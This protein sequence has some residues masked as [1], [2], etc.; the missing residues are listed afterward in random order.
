[1][2][3]SWFQIWKL[4]LLRPSV[5]S[6]REI[7]RQPNASV[8]SAFTSVFLCVSASLLVSLLLG[9]LLS[10]LGVAGFEGIW[11]P[12][13]SSLFLLA[14]YVVMPLTAGFL[15]VGALIAIAA[16]TQKVASVLGGVGNVSMVIPAVAALFAPLA[17]IHFLTL[18]LGPFIGSFGSFLLLYAAILTVIAFE[19]VN[20]IGWLK[21]VAST[22]VVILVVL[23][24]VRLTEAAL[25][26]L[27]L[28]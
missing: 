7:V 6:F 11:D 17:A 22:S 20:Q 27:T 26:R 15:A 2:S 3:R 23:T 4:A 9:L 12:T 21:A 14:Y 10:R 28:P 25:I 24:F 13:D 18:G 16:L 5:A 1:M 8:K 19:A